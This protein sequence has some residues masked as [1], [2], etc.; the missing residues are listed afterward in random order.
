MGDNRKIDAF[1]DIAASGMSLLGKGLEEPKPPLLQDKYFEWANPD[2]AD[3]SAPVAKRKMSTAEEL[4]EEL[5]RMRKQYAPYMEQHAPDLP[6]CRL[7][8]ELR[9]FDWRIGTAEDELDFVGALQGRGLWTK[10][11]VPHYGEPLG[12]AF[13]LYR[14]SFE[15]T[16]AMLRPGRLFVRFKAVDYK[17]HVF[18]NGCYLG[19]H[20]GFFAP[21]ELDATR[22]LKIGTN[23]ILIK[24]E[25][26]FVCGDDPGGDKIYAATGIGYDDPERGWH[27]CPP[28]MGIYQGVSIEARSAVH[29]GTLY[30][31][32]MPNLK[33]AQAWV[34]VC[35]ETLTA[36]E[37]KL[38]ISVYGRNFRQTVIEKMTFTPS[39]G[40]EVGLGDSFTEANLKAEGKL[41]AAIPMLAERGNNRYIVPLTLPSARL[42]ESETPWLYQIHVELIMD[43]QVV[44]TASSHFGMRTFRME[45]EAAPKGS[46]YLNDKQIRLRGANTMGH[47][48]QCVAR[49]DWTQL[50]DDILLA[51]ICHMNFLRITQRPVQPEVY[52]YCDMLGLMVQTDLPLF[53]VLSRVQ[54]CEAVRQSEEM[55]RLIRNH[56]CAIMVSYINEPFPNAKNK[57][58][59]YLTRPELLDFFKA[60][61]L[62][63][64]LN[65]PDRVIKHVDGDYDPP[66][67]SLPDNHCYP[68]WYNGHGLDIGRLHKGYWLP[69]KPGWYYGCGEFGSEGLDPVPLMRD[70]Y[71]ASWMPHHSDEERLWSP[72]SIVGAQTGR[73][74]YFFYE[75][76]DTL[77]AWVEESQKHQAWATRIMT[78]A[79]RRDG[80]MN[81][82]AIHLFIDAFP[83]G[84]MKTIMDVERRPK[85]AYFAY[86]DALEPLMANLRT[87][88]LTGYTGDEIR[89]EAWICNDRTEVPRDA[90]V[91]CTIK[92][93]DR[94][95][96][97]ASQAAH[98][99]VC[100]TAFQGFI[101]F[102]APNSQ[103]RTRI[104]VTLAICDCAGKVLHDTSLDIEVFPRLDSFATL[105]KDTRT[106][107]AIL[108]RKGG[109]AYQLAEELGL[110]AAD[111]TEGMQPDTVIVDDI[112][113]MQEH[114]P[115]LAALAARGARIVVLESEPGEYTLLGEPIVVKSCGMQPLHF[116]SR[117]SG[118]RFIEGFRP[119]DF[120]HWYSPEEDLI[121]PLLRHTITT[122]GEVSP[123]LLSGNTNDQGEWGPA[124]AAV[125]QRIG[126]G[127]LVLCQ[128]TLAGRCSTNPVAAEFA[129]R[130]IG[131][132]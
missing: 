89:M 128:L 59:R 88:R 95:L 41:N 56:P 70:R 42:W 130:L 29:I 64:R 47:E 94:L 15:V 9:A 31:R 127:S 129:L 93:G 121:M 71:P 16:E 78:E 90:S 80:R 92:E 7:R 12:S 54:F 108:G 119:E 72:S 104:T 110:T 107:P 123:I 125:E 83:S 33:E 69:V 91:H 99:P 87:D 36:P 48:Q 96:A 23:C 52:D 111:W 84:W 114:E 112:T 86:R 4:D 97:T 25:N 43:G 85:A 32:P 118:H 122:G 65:N 120:R 20:E 113:L 6:D 101:R 11:S 77:K 55:E 45:T 27:H 117:K 30:V 46:L 66:S 51:K 28:G 124:L 106:E 49:E 17:A 73:F 68:C 39:T 8:V 57:P 131:Q 98:I 1:A 21:F 76:P 22:S 18:V 63:V 50:R 103:A 13:T 102:M 40:I 38:R 126:L 115:E 105:D 26:D 100:D 58:H 132:P 116:V 74:H 37:V 79:F 75:T 14:T 2:K 35:N 19:S 3:Q 10:V 67:D 53:G 5:E 60:A 34:E 61:D 24:V 62:A 82:F 109:L 44:D 81:T